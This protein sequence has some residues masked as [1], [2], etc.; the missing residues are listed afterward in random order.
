MKI[1]VLIPC[2]NEEKTITQ[3]IESCLKQT[4]KID[5]III[6]D[7][8]STDNSPQILKKLNKKPVKVVRTPKNTGNKSYAQEYGLQFITGD[9]FVTV[10]ADTLLAPNFIEYIERDFQ[11]PKIQAVAGYIKSLK[12][13]WLTACREIDYVIGQDIHKLAQAKLNALMVIPG[14]GGAFRT[15]IFRKYISFDH[16]TLTEDLDFTYKLYKNNFKIIYNKKAV[17]YTQDPATLH[18]Y[19]NQMRRWIGGG[20]Q[21]LIKHWQVVLKHPG[22][23]LE[24]SLIYFE[25]LISGV[26]FFVLPFI[27]IFYFVSFLIGYAIAAFIAGIYSLFRRKRFDLILFAPLFPFILVLNSWIFLEQFIKEVILRKKNL[28]WFK[29]ERRTI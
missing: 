24:I 4:R 8:S 3:C 14:C 28:V 21:N 6:V 9:I 25:G 20:W 1:S 19:I 23:A 29:P 18:S 13:N 5:Q 2:Y 10:D 12:H 7:D 27:N 11:N 26:L 22:H 15:N 17:V 16:D